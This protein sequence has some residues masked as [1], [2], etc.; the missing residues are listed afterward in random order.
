FW[1]GSTLVTL[2]WAEARTGHC[3]QG[4][5]TIQHGLN[6]FR[7]TGARV[8]L[9]SWLGALADAYCCAG[10]FQQ[11]QTSIA[12]AIHW[13][14]TS[15]DCYYLPQLHQLQTRLAAQ[16]DDESRCSAV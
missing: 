12:E 3:E 14:E 7:S 9:T 11:A 5:A 8:Q 1:H 16:Q 10:Q 6:V 4:I 2:G 13:A 15:G